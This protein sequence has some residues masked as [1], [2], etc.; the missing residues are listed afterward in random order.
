[1][2]SANVYLS[3]APLEG[4]RPIFAGD[5]GQIGADLEAC[6]ELGAEKVFLDLS[7]SQEASLLERFLQRIEQLRAL[8]P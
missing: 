5:L 2:K 6:R 3:E 7:F 4:E 8:A 1:M